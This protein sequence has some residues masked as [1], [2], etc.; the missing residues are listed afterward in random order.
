M[1]YL[2]DYMKCNFILLTVPFENEEASQEKF[3]NLS[4]DV[5]RIWFDRP[6][7]QR[8]TLFLQSQTYQVSYIQVISLQLHLISFTWLMPIYSLVTVFPLSF[9]CQSE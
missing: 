2:I 5:A 1:L 3:Y 8:S 6:W 4:R 7:S 9:L